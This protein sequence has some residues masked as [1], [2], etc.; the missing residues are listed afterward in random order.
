M[1]LSELII[2]FEIYSVSL[3]FRNAILRGIIATDVV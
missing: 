3:P 1:P 2:L